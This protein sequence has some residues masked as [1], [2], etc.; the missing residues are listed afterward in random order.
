LISLILPDTQLSI[1]PGYLDILQLKF[2][3]ISEKKVN[4][5]VGTIRDEA[6]EPIVQEYSGEKYLWQTY[7]TPIGSK[8]F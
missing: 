7:T 2:N 1:K 5:P 8:P 4:V 3:D 6:D